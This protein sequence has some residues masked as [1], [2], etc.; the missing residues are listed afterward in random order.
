[1]R[2]EQLAHKNISERQVKRSLKQSDLS[3]HRNCWAIFRKTIQYQLARK[4]IE[5]FSG[6]L[7]ITYW[8][9]WRMQQ[10]LRGISKRLTSSSKQKWQSLLSRCI[11]LQFNNLL[12]HLLL[13]LYLLLLLFT[14]FYF[15]QVLITTVKV[16]TQPHTFVSYHVCYSRRVITIHIAYICV[17]FL[18]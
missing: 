12:F 4:S 11:Q 14:L 8:W 13:L 7:C 6:T 16:L 3:E 17:A 1:M 5:Q 15:C 2:S 18:S 9:M 10:A